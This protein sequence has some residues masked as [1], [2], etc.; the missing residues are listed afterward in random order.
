M[1]GRRVCCTVVWLG[2][3]GSG[4]SI[5]KRRDFTRALSRARR[6]TPTRLS[7]QW[8]SCDGWGYKATNHPSFATNFMQRK[9]PACGKYCMT[10]RMPSCIL[11]RFCKRSDGKRG[12]TA[13]WLDAWRGGALRLVLRRGG[14]GARGGGC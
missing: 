14:G 2:E 6:R 8:R 7:P 3:T 5:T 13:N 12:G 10:A 4:Q 9:Q 11:D 1:V